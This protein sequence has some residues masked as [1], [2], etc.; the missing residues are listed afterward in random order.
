MGPRVDGSR[1]PNWVPLPVFQLLLIAL[2]GPAGTAAQLSQ[3]SKG[4]DVTIWDYVVFVNRMAFSSDFGT[5][6]IYEYID[7]EECN[8]H[9]KNCLFS[10]AFPF[11]PVPICY[12]A[13]RRELIPEHA[14]AD[15]CQQH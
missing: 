2:S 10:R 1:E 14:S 5:R 7:V 6:Y 3:A 11:L 8:S 13:S 9:P 12:R 15:I 4:S